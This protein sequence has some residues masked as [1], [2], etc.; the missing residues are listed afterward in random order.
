MTGLDELR[1]NQIYFDQKVILDQTLPFC[2]A[3]VKGV[4]T[5]GIGLILPNGEAFLEGR[6]SL[7]RCPAQRL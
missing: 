5:D 7:N 1:S 4:R 6:I 3:L 2:L